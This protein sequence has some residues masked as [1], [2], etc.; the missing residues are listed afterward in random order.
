MKM[1]E[2][3]ASNM[4]SDQK[5]VTLALLALVRLSLLLCPLAI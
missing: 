3:A 2:L 5:V 4:L 1:D